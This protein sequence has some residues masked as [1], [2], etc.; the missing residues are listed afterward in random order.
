MPPF[1]SHSAQTSSK[2]SSFLIRHG[3]RSL[4]SLITSIGDQKTISRALFPGMKTKRS[5]EPL[6]KIVAT[7][8]R[9]QQQQQQP[10]VL[11]ATYVGLNDGPAPGTVV[12]IVLGSVGGLILVMW[13]IYSCFYMNSTDTYEEEIVRRTTSRSAHRSSRSRSEMTQQRRSS[14]RSPQRVRRETVIVEERHGPPVV[15]REDDIVEVIEERSRSRTPPPRRDR[16]S[17]DRRET[18][19]YYRPVDPLAYGGGNAPPRRVAR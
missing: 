18:D 7:I 17:S 1:L 13:L 11:P 4:R 12:G 5:L 10:T 14:P 16:R 19:G 6:V 15:D 8:S 9:R 2:S 3:P